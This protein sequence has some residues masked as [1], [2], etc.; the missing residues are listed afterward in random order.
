MVRV[1]KSLAS[2]SSKEMNT[3]QKRMSVALVIILLHKIRHLFD[4]KHKVT[5]G[6]KLNGAGDQSI[7]NSDT[8]P[9]LTE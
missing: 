9:M 7:M 3:D 5:V 8:V 6:Q 4:G 2:H 1:F